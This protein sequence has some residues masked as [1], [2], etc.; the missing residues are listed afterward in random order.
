M[1]VW[2]VWGL[3]FYAYVGCVQ[4]ERGDGKDD[5]ARL[6]QWVRDTGAVTRATGSDV[7]ITITAVSRQYWQPGRCVRLT[8]RLRSL[9]SSH[10]VT[11]SGSIFP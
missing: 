6:C 10:Q 2:I 5:S 1:A 3:R 4:R 9:A 8:E 11:K 7:I